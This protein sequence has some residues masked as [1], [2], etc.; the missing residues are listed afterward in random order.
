M[1]GV[2]DFD[3]SCD[4]RQDYAV[5]LNLERAPVREAV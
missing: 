4:G 5:S 1:N 2:F 3:V